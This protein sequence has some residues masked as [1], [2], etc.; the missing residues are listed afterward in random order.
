MVHGHDTRACDFGNRFGNEQIS[1]TGTD[2][3][4]NRFE[5]RFGNMQ[6]Y[7]QISG[8]TDSGMNRFGAEQIQEHAGMNRLWDQIRE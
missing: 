8:G 6:K 4:V 7:D 5:N 3:A 2:S 1:G